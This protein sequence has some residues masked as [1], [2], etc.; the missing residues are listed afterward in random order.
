MRYFDLLVFYAMMMI[1]LFYSKQDFPPRV[2][3]QVVK[4]K[5]L[6]QGTLIDCYWAGTAQRHSFHGHI[7]GYLV[8]NPKKFSIF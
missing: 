4:A 3:Q 2:Q 1:N 5:K 7:G 8:H 6:K